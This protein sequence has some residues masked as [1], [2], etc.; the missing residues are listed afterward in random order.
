MRTIFFPRYLLLVIFFILVAGYTVYQLSGL[1][2]QPTL[3]IEQPTD[4]QTVTDE[5]L[6]IRGQTTGLSGLTVN[7]EKLIM[8]ERGQFETKLLLAAG[9]NTIRVTGTD[10][11]GRIITKKLQLVY[12]QEREGS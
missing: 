3:V 9:Y 7:D 2:R 8:D 5:L 1:F 10:R 11:F 12:A 6:V 4:G